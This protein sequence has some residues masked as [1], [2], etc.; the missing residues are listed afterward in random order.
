MRKN[1][2]LVSF[3]L[4]FLLSLLLNSSLAQ[5]RSAIVHE[6]QI[7]VKMKPGKKV[8]ALSKKIGKQVSRL[9]SL[10]LS[11]ATYEILQVPEDVDPFVFAV[12]LEK[13]GLVEFAYPNIKKQV[14]TLEELLSG[15]PYLPNDP[16]FLG[17]GNLTL[18][19]A[20]ENPRF[21]Q[22]G[23]L[24]TNAPLAWKYT[25]GDPGVIVAIIDTGIKFLHPEL[26][27]RLWENPG[28]IPGD[29]KDNDGNGF[30]DDIY[31]WDF[32]D[33][34]PRS[35]YLGDSDVADP[36]PASESHGTFT[37][38]VVGAITNNGNGIAGVAGGGNG[39]QG[40]RL[41]ILRVGTNT[42]IS[43]AAEVAAIDYALNQ[44]AMIMNMSFGG[45]PGGDPEEEAVRNAWER[46]GIIIAA[47][48][49]KG[50]GNALGL[51]WPAALPEAICVGATTIFPSNK[52]Y[53][54]T[55]IIA[56]TIASY[57]KTGPE[58]DIVAPG[59]NI[60][61]IMGTR[62]YT[63]A[64]DNQF[65]GT[66]ASTPLV[67]GFAA[68]IK[69]YYPDFTNSQLRDKIYSSAID[70]GDSGWDEVY[71]NGRIDMAKAFPQTPPSV[72]AG[73]YNLDGK[74]NEADVE[75]VRKHYGH[76]SSYGGA[77]P[78]DSEDDR[79]DGNKDGV[80]DELDVFIVGR[81]YTG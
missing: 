22:W 64:P 58:M 10:P 9:Y 21:S 41:M 66:S 52:V 73:D 80:V 36:Q 35:G 12:E 59:S 69:S 50:A 27:G 24:Y 48:G 62:D 28:E 70:M 25:T 55:P 74:V 34:D 38:G 32:A 29:G 56:E 44:G 68:L 7:I 78:T 5:A 8:S 75:E 4:F 11:Y 1:S 81:N 39:H 71:G 72:L 61:T 2:Y 53:S 54:S 57:S 42:S 3:F 51:D 15:N 20:F 49:N 37:A 30:V 79:I 13:S 47:G 60:L 14:S 23:L 6:N 77:T 17:E 76:K 63:L 16:Y 46:G 67:A 43:V 18:E 33:I 45:E 26:N 19:D 40:V 31:G 65:F